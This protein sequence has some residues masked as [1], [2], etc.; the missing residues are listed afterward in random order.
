[1]IMCQAFMIVF[2]TFTPP[3]KFTRHPITIMR[4]DLSQYAPTGIIDMTIMP[5]EDELPVEIEEAEDDEIIAAVLPPPHKKAKVNSSQSIKA[6]KVK[7]NQHNK[8]GGSKFDAETHDKFAQE[9]QE[10]N[11]DEDDV[12]F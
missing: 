7:K 11:E 5:E 1:M 2:T 6:N 4:N 9:E 12:E 10:W 8:R 3:Y